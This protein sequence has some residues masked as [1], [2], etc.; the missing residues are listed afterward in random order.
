MAEKRRQT[1]YECAV[2]LIAQATERHGKE[3][4]LNKEKTQ[5]L[6]EICGLIEAIIH[7]NDCEYYDVGVVEN[8]MQFVIA[9][10]CDEMIL[11]KEMAQT[12]Y[13]L[14]KKVDSFVFS[15]PEIDMMRVE[16]RFDNIWKRRG[17]G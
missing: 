8:T 5:E 16:F 12:F 17:N 11:D 9:I 6:P 14:V 13:K 3:F 15:R 7:N 4:L 10:V 2:D 1:C